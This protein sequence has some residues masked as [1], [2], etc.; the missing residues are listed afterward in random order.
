MKT[1]RRVDS[2]VSMG[3]IGSIV[4][5]IAASVALIMGAGI[6]PASASPTISTLRT[7]TN[8]TAKPGVATITVSWHGPNKTGVTYTVTS[9]PA[10]K[11][12]VVVSGR[13]CTI[14]VT[15][16]TP[17]RFQVTASLGSLSSAASALTSVVPHRTLLILAGQSNAT[18]AD[19]YAIDPTTGSDYMK[20]PY[21]NGA[22]KVSTIGWLAWLVNPEKGHARDGQ[23]PL[24][25]P[26]TE[27]GSTGQ[28]VQIFG[29]EIGWARQVY[30]D[31]GLPV[32]VIKTAMPATN[33]P[34][35]LPSA[36]F[37]LFPQ[38]VARL[39]SSMAAD[40]KAGQL[41]TIG[42]FAIYQGE[43]DAGDPTLADSYQVNLSA[44][45]AGLRSDLPANGSTPIVLVRESLADL[46]SVWQAFGTCGTTE[47]CTAVAIGDAEVR[48]ADAWAAAHIP[49]VIEVDTLGLPRFDG[50]I[51]LTNTSELTV[52][53][54]I[55]IASD[56]LMP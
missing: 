45:I 40:A 31:T 10:G 48:A 4:V 16:S 24:D 9:V 34:Q 49:H 44:F 54:E 21:T 12:C 37:D 41:D 51:H 18:G 36:T 26:Q 23:V 50:L 19:S 6:V 35:W 42:A 20:A 27:I 43:G 47:N 53:Q 32:S 25:S 13:R 28:A 22:D 46:I 1:P 38:M 39:T 7:P 8:V 52:G 14:P 15:D 2:L 55:A 30:V 29:P 5:S 33:L 17:W 56:R 3:R 11:G